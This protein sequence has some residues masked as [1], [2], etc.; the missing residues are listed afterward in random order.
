M[1]RNLILFIFS[2]FAVSANAQY[3][4]VIDPYCIEAVGQNLATQKAIEGEN[5]K[6]LDSIASKQNKL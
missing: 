6:R 3:R 5:N 4:V 2:V 1:F